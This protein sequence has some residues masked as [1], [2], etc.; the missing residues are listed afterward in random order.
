MNEKKFKKLLED[1]CTRL[2]GIPL[3]KSGKTQRYTVLVTAIVQYMS[4]LGKPSA[5]SKNNGKHIYYLSMEF[6]LGT[7][8]KNALRALNL[9]EICES[10]F[11]S[12]DTALCDLYALE[13]DPGLG[14]GGLGRLAACY[15]DGHPTCPFPSPDFHQIRI[16]NLPPKDR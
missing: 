8:L 9:T 11:G 15:L 6:L 4:T 5:A 14:N 7:S 1:T 3:N 12:L 16:R 2:F 10:I 13:P